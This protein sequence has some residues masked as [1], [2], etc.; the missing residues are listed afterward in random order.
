MNSKLS[1]AGATLSVLTFAATGCGG[2]D[3]N[4]ALSYEETGDEL[5]AI[6]QQYDTAAAEEELT[7]NADRDAPVLAEIT[8]ETER[9]LEEIRELEVNEE[10]VDARDQ[11]VS[12]VEESLARTE[13]LKELAERG[14]QAAYMRRIR[15]LERAAPEIAEE[16]DAAAAQLGAEACGQN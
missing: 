2:D 11:F 3:D 12:V 7:G 16:A 14:D 4:Q 1:L 13:A 8:A 6:C 15:E 10:L 9:G 5:A